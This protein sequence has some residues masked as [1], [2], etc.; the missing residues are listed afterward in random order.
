MSLYTI[1]K[2]VDRMNQQS[3]ERFDMQR[4]PMR[5]AWYLRPLTFLLSAPDV[6]LHR[7]KITKRRAGN[8]KPPYI[9]LC[10]HNAFFDF[11]VATMATF[12]HCAIGR[13]Q[14][15]LLSLQLQRLRLI[16]SWQHLHRQVSRSRLVLSTPLRISFLEIT[17]GTDTAILTSRYSLPTM[18]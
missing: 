4:P 13:S 17:S 12:P 5:T 2:T 7:A 10:N 14:A 8:L 3:L 1:Q 16:A 6:L 11:K 9:L 15:S 18:W